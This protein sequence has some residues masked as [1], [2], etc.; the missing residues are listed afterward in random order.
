VTTA[1]LVAGPRVSGTAL[2]LIMAMAGRASYCDE[3]GG[4]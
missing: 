2:A 3:L 4:S 1:A